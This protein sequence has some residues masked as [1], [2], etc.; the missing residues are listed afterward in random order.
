[1][2]PLLHVVDNTVQ[3]QRLQQYVRGSYAEAQPLGI[4][5][6]LLDRLSALAWILPAEAPVL[7]QEC[8]AE[9]RRQR[10]VLQSASSSP[11][12]EGDAEALFEMIQTLRSEVRYF[13]PEFES[14]RQY[15]ASSSNLWHAFSLDSLLQNTLALLQPIWESRE[16]TLSTHNTPALP[17]LK[18]N[19]Q[20]LQQALIALL[21]NSTQAMEQRREI[22]LSTVGILD[23]QGRTAGVQLSVQDSGHGVLAEE[24][25]IIHQPLYTTHPLPD[26]LGMGL[27]LAERYVQEAHG[28]LELFSTPGEGTCVN[29][30]LPT[31][32]ISELPNEETPQGEIFERARSFLRRVA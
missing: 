2:I 5:L 21:L 23:K 17:L 25:E 26:S 14:I 9:V 15:V 13:Q 30:F 18:A 1:M 6:E 11:L 8:S 24:I 12:A 19:P 4:Y 10:K 32:H 31:I 27:T 3:Q 28:R 22:T 7:L 16:I 20:R 29:L